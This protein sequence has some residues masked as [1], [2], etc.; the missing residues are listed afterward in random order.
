MDKKE[1]E[2]GE[3]SSVDLWKQVTK[4]LSHKKSEETSKTSSEA[5]NLDGIKNKIEK[6]SMGRIEEIREDEIADGN[7]QYFLHN[8]NISKR[9]KFMFL[10]TD[11]S[12]RNKPIFPI[13]NTKV[14]LKHA[15]IPAF[16]PKTQ[17]F[18]FSDPSFFKK[19]DLD[20]LFF[21]FYFSKGTIQ[22][23]YAAIRLKSFGWRFHLRYRIWFQRLDEP[24]LITPEYEKGEFLFFDYESSWNFMKKNDFVFEYCFLE[25]NDH[26]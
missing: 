25:H 19:F 13:L 18:M 3:I 11:N 1:K 20:T 10:E 14:N 9:D 22:Q 6:I 17:P 7:A 24:K 26:Y 8:K 5:L 15:K 4:Q 2:N 21:I 12:Y 16:F 23:T